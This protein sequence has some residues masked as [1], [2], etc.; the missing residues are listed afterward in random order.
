M[1]AVAYGPDVLPVMLTSEAADG[2]QWADLA[3][4]GHTHGVQ[5]RLFGRSVLPLSQREQRYLSGWHT[6][7]GLPILIT[8]G[9]G[10]EGINLRLGSTPEVWLITLR[11]G[12]GN[13]H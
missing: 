3:L 11:R 6:E 13:R 9:V 12:L 8:Q 2:G 1:L 7:N 5:L 4:C 10:C